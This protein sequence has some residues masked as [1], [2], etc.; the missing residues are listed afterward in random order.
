MQKDKAAATSLNAFPFQMLDVRLYRICTE[1]RDIQ[2]K[3]E[4]AL[5]LQI[6]LQSDDSPLN[7]EQFNLLLAFETVLPFTDD[8]EY[9]TSIAIEGIFKAI[10][11]VETIRPE[12]IEQFKSRDSILLLW[13]YLRQTLQDIAIRMGI[14]VAP[15]PIID[16]RALISRQNE[17]EVDTND[18]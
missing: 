3:D 4:V 11:D 2:S 8:I 10:V 17:E 7:A 9:F 12:L 1:P 16:A 6:S 13:P 15:L 14:D 5:P 18:Q